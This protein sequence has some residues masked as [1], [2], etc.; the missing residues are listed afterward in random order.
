[1]KPV[2][3][4]AAALA[5]ALLAGCGGGSGRLSKS[6]YRAK[7]AT[8][9]READRAQS[10]V[11]KGLRAKSVRELHARLIAFAAASRRLGDEA[12][13]LKPPKDAEAANGELVRGEHDTAQAT[14]AAAAAI[15]KLRT[16]R[17]AI[18]YLQ[19]SLGN[20]KGAHE[21]DDALAKLKKL[22]YTKGS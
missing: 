2:V 16:P 18:A 20:A 10:D 14:R 13:K 17:A 1:M 7:L 6:D 19:T 21:L 5:A 9:S 12:A 8:L 22:G 15:T 4:L 11:E 3:C